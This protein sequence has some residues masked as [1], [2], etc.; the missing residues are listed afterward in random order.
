MATFNST[1]KTYP[2]KWQDGLVYSNTLNI[3]AQDFLTDDNAILSERFNL[4]EFY[5]ERQKA[6]L[7]KQVTW[8]W[9]KCHLSARTCEKIILNTDLKDCVQ[10]YA[11]ITH[12]KDDTSPHTHLLIKFYRNERISS[13]LVSYFHI[14]NCDS[15][16]H[17]VNARFNYLTHNSDKC[18]SEKKYQYSLDEIVTDN[19]K[20][21]QDYIEPVDNV[22]KNIIND[23]LDGFSERTLVF[24]YGK[25]Y[26]Y[27]RQQY[28]ECA[29][30]IACQE[31]IKITK[32]FT[33]KS[34]TDDIIALYDGNGELVEIARN[35]NALK[36]AI[37][38]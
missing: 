16:E 7:T 30:I 11:I 33:I 35:L 25:D 38:G 24:L 10:H 31:N 27:H 29:R 12:D 14:D 1:R 5:T 9:C 22:P 20:F 13:R 2:Q 18:R 26:I 37:N 36:G 15:C 19:I 34:I 3:T 4:V 17:S 6:Y 21:W 32:D 23:I 28:H 8:A